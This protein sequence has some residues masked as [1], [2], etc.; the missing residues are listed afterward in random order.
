MLA[1]WVGSN[2]TR[3]AN[4]LSPGAETY[5][6]LLPQDDYGVDER[7]RAHKGKFT[8][9]KGGGSRY[10]QSFGSMKHYTAANNA[11]QK[12]VKKLGFEATYFIPNLP[13][14]WY[15]IVKFRWLSAWNNPEDGYY[16]G[17]TRIHKEE[18]Q[19]THARVSLV[20]ETME[21]LFGKEDLSEYIIALKT[22][23][24]E[25]TYTT[26][27]RFVNI[28]PGDSREKLRREKCALANQALLAA[29]VEER[30]QAAL[31]PTK[32]PKQSSPLVAQ[33]QA[34]LLAVDAPPPQALCT[35]IWIKYRQTEALTCLIDLFCSAIWEFDLCEAAEGLQQEYR[36]WLSQGNYWLIGDWIDVT[37]KHYLNHRRLVIRK[38]PHLRHVDQVLAWDTAWQL[39]V[40]LASSNGGVGQ[41]S[42][43]IYGEGIYEPNSTFVLTKSRKSLDWAAG[44]DYT[45]LGITREYQ[46]VPRNSGSLTD[47]PP[48]I[49]NVEGH[50]R[51]W[52]EKTTWTYA[53]VWLF[54]GETIPT[55]CVVTLHSA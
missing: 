4:F 22:K 6:Q 52:V 13:L 24:K 8:Y 33:A 41:H 32:R 55:P 42:V 30:K 15:E 21:K 29:E 17:V 37:N 50:G 47:G 40:L 2:T 19:Y 36:A 34:T 43:T 14:Y 20:T 5:V 51:G 31:H 45:C 11:H 44:V 3:E 48:G 10:I 27:Y 49:Y 39:V 38:L 9:S 1:S 28:P 12:R 35:T 25:N 23:A 26:R 16:E 46:I 54:S 18:G 7:P 53:K